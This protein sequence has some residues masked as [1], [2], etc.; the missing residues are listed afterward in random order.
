MKGL[1]IINPVSGTKIVHNRIPLVLDAFLRHPECEGAQVYYTHKK[2]DATETAANLRPGQYDF[3]CAVGGDGTLGEVAAGLYKSGSG[4]PMAIIAA[5]TSN[6]FSTSLDIPKLPEDIARMLLNG[7]HVPM[8]LGI[9]NGRYFYSE[10]GGGGLAEVAHSTPAD[11]K[12]RFGYLAYLNGGLKKYGNLKLDTVPL[13]YELDGV[14]KEID[15][16]CFTITNATRAGGFTT[17]A[18]KAKIND[19]YMDLCVIKKVAPLE[20]LPALMQINAGEHAENSKWVEYMQVKKLKVRAKNEED[21]FV[22]DV[23][24]EDGG[25]LPLDFEIVPAAINLIIPQ[26]SA[27]ANNVLAE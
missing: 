14:E 15:T 10:V 27:A 20:V 17:L 25:N 4:I 5:G 24:G 2:G 8:D 1:F 18:P 23:D 26:N 19:G 12:A 3:V 7:R 13:I 9:V 6:D 16:F 11:Q 21:K 22:V